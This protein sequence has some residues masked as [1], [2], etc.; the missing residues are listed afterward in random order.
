[1]R[2]FIPGEM[3]TQLCSLLG[4]LAQ[5]VDPGSVT[6]VSPRGEGTQDSERQGLEGDREP[7]ILHPLP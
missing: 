6:E 4:A 1:M 2:G 5:K 7:C 3:S